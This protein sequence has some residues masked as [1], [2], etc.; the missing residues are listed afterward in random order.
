MSVADGE[1]PMSSTAN[2]LSYAPPPAP[3]AGA[4]GSITQHPWASWFAWR[5]VKLYMTRRYCWLRTIHR[6]CV[7]KN[8]FQSCEYTDRPED[9][10]GA[11]PADHKQ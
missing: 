6:R 3:Q 5:P 9:Y 10:P 11:T 2:P 1:T 4:D 7:T 8:G